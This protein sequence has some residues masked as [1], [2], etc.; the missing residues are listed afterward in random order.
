MAEE[1]RSSKVSERVKGVSRRS[2]L[3]AAGGVAVWGTVGTILGTKAYAQKKTLTVW[4]IWPEQWIREIF[5]V[6]EKETG[7]HIE[8]IRQS[9]G[10]I[11]ARVIA[12]AGKPDAS[13]MFGGPVPTF[14]PA[15]EKGLLERYV[16]PSA[17]TLPDKYKDPDGYWMGIAVDPLCFY[18]NK[19]FLAEKRLEAPRSW[20]DF[21]RPEYAKSIQMADPRTSGTAYQ[22][23]VTLITIMHDEDLAFFYM[24]KLKKSVQV[25][26][27]HGG[28]GI[29]PISTGEAGTGVYFLVDALDAVHKGYPTVVS[30][31]REGVT[32]PLEAIALLKGAPQPELG[33]ELINWA[34]SGKMQR[35]YKELNIFF[36]PTQ[37][38][39][40]P[41]TGINLTE[42][43]IVPYDL[44]WAGRER[45]RLIKRWVDEVLG[46]K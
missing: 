6:F 41:P 25:Y 38:K 5:P 10:Q 26:T 12:S 19:E 34:V 32:A 29:I 27:E 17:A 30:F 37:P 36:L 16:P 13:V 18:S 45:E 14:L 23:I 1:I 46:G 35:L 39:V 43:R 11:L 28:G 15:K 2:F 40:E 33:K 4:S 22:R 21:L 20:F 42:A 7:I 8:W 9:S 3:K 31:P 24:K 44:E